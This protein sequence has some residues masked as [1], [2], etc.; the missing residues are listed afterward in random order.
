MIKDN[1]T[2]LKPNVYAAI[3][4]SRQVLALIGEKWVSLI[5][6]ALD[7]RTL[8]FGELKRVCEGVSQKMLTQSLKKLERDGIVIRTSYSDELVLRVEYQ[9]SDLGQTLVNVVN[10]AR[11]WAESNLHVIEK[12]RENFDKHFKDKA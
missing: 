6:G 12:N 1:E 2:D 8:R 3:C 4:P 11:M 9:L 10:N 7:N 5:I